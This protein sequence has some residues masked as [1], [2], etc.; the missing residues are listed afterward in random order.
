L[1]TLVA[2][3]PACAELCQTFLGAVAEMPV[4]RSSRSVCS[5]SSFAGGAVLRLAAEAI[6]PVLETLQKYLN[7]CQQWLG[8]NPWLRKW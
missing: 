2:V 1:A 8:D 7:P 3:G 5:A 6:E 4:S